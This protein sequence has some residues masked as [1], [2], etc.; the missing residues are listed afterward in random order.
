MFE[1]KGYAN[2]TYIQGEMVI[3]EEDQEELG[4][5][6]CKRLEKIGEELAAEI[7]RREKKKE[8]MLALLDSDSDYSDIDSDVE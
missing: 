6:S 1:P 3:Q 4:I 5:E 8:Q 7:T 2:S